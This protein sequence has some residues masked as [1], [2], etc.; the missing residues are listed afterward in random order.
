MTSE[1]TS[2]PSA[3]LEADVRIGEAAALVGVSTR[4]LRYYQELGMLRPS[5]RSA[6]GARRYSEADI[7]RL[8]R[9]R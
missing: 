8:Q 5:A 2:T 4:T 6:G 1:L 9:I 7:A 3:A